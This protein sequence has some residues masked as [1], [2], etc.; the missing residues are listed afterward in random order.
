MDMFWDPI[1]YEAVFQLAKQN[2]PELDR[3]KIV[4]S[5]NDDEVFIGVTAR[6]FVYATDKDTT[7]AKQAETGDYCRV[8]KTATVAEFFD[9]IKKMLHRVSALVEEGKTGAT[10]NSDKA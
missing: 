6:Y 2:F 4:I 7:F 1:R 10:S 8:S 3:A 9:G 5:D